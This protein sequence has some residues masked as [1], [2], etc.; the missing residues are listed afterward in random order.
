MSSLDNEV[1]RQSV[2]RS[3]QYS[4]YSSCEEIPPSPE[5]HADTEDD[6]DESSS[7]SSSSYTTIS[8][9]IE[10]NKQNTKKRTSKNIK[11]KLSAFVNNYAEI[12]NR[13]RGDSKSNDSTRSAKKT[14]LADRWLSKINQSQTTLHESQKKH[15]MDF[16]NELKK[17]QMEEENERLHLLKES[18]SNNFV[19]DNCSILSDEL[20]WLYLI[21]SVQINVECVN[22]KDKIL[23]NSLIELFGK[24][25]ESVWG[26]KLRVTESNESKQISPFVID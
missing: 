26:Y 18:M 19:F 8:K 14:K 5:P 17:Q 15:A 16:M 13:S 23:K 21:K 20:I 3:I 25:V 24:K 11:S 10:E 12:K 4:D 22:T 9:Q 7:S 6:D 1:H 2:S